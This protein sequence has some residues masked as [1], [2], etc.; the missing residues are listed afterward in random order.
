MADGYLS[1]RAAAQW[2]DVS[3]KT[4]DRLRAAGELEAIKLADGP[5]GRVRISAA[6]LQAYTER[7]Q[8]HAAATEEPT[9]RFP[10]PAL[11]ALRAAKARRRAAAPGGQE[12]AA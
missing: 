12:A 6:S 4:I 10:I 8:Q 2:L 7:R 1:K 5:G 11:D 3:E 9:E